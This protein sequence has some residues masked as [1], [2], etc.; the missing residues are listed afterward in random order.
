MKKRNLVPLFFALAVTG[1]LSAK[2]PVAVIEPAAKAILEESITATGGR[3]AMAKIKSRKIVGKIE[4]PA[5]GMEM[6]L[7][8]SQKAP[9]KMVTK[10]VIPNMMTAEQGFNG[11]TGWSK[12]TV[13]GVRKLAGAELSQA[14]ESAAIFP[15]LQIMNNL[16]SATLL[17]DVSE[18]D[19]TL[20]VVK[21]TSKESPAKTL[22]FDKETK[23]LVKMSSSMATGPG[24]EMEVTTFLGNYKEKDGVKYPSVMKMKMMGQDVTITYSSIEHNVEIDDAVFAIP[25]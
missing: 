12:D 6:T 21:I 13:Q 4:M 16:L 18:A 11:E 15:E 24:G 14:K 1:P 5:Q 22:Y 8:L 9:M 20:K 23:L 25:E 2:E 19:Q 10:M 17:E 3:E 7:T